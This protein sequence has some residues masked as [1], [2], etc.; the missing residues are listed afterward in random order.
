M[1]VAALE[2]ECQRVIAQLKRLEELS[3]PSAARLLKK[4]PEF[5]R[6]TFPVIVH[7]TRSHHVRVC[8]IEAYR[9]KRTVYPTKPKCIPNDT[10]FSS[11]Q[12]SDRMNQHNGTHQ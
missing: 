4:T 6:R 2:R 5:I 9:Q 7:G 12:V 10:N 3:V 1:S 8:D 11:R